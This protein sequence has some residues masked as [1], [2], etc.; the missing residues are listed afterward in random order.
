MEIE[1]APPEFSDSPTYPP[2]KQ[3][4]G[5][6]WYQ[7]YMAALFE[8]DRQQAREKI[9]FATRLIYK[10]ELHLFSQASSATERTALNRAFHAL[11]ALQVCH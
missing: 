10:R 8:I 3:Y 11:H 4:R 6:E 2:E 7:A 1:S 5:E 9:E